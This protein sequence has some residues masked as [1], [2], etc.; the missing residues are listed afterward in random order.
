MG[1][2][3][4]V[5]EFSELAAEC[6]I[7]AGMDPLDWRDCL[8][9]LGRLASEGY[10]W[11]PA[12][13][14]TILRFSAGRQIAIALTDCWPY[15][16][17]AIEEDELKA[18][19]GDYVRWLS[20][21]NDER[22]CGF[23]WALLR[24]QPRRQGSTAQVPI[25]WLM[26]QGRLKG[27]I[28][29]PSLELAVALTDE[30][31]AMFWWPDERWRA[32]D[33]PACSKPYIQFLE[34]SSSLVRAASAKAL[35]RLHTG[36]RD[37]HDTPPVTQLLV[38]VARL[39][40]E[41]PGVAGPFLEGADWGIDDWSDQLDGFDMRQWFLDTLRNSGK[42]PDWPEAQALEFYAQEYLCSDGA[43]IEELLEMGREDLAL[44]TATNLP[45]N[46]ELLRPV[47]ESMARHPN[48]QIARS[49]QSYLAEHG[50]STGRQWL[51]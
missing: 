48:D 33:W 26:R 7:Y 14:A 25:Y 27:D 42:E 5:N 24:A 21:E 39:E 9:A 46:V 36:L 19:L 23:C 50:Q 12:S 28:E 17:D 47:L 1:R 6:E 49:V 44:M 45:E 16:H 4:T 8:G 2:H 41:R 31:T 32:A 11:L 22:V 3:A 40:A 20:G 35:G 29:M 10:D 38:E 18:L 15:Q 13:E 51:N 43:A 37:R 34:H 30:E